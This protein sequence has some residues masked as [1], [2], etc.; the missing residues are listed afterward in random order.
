MDDT[1]IIAL[2][3]QRDERAIAETSG[4]YGDY[5][6]AIAYNI[7][8]DRQDAEECLND[9]WLGAWNAIPPDCPAN[10]KLYLAKITRNLSFNRYKLKNRKKRGGSE[11]ETL[12]D[13]I[14]EFLPD[15]TNVEK[16]IEDNEFIQAVNSFLRTLPERERGIFIR[17]YFYSEKTPVISRRYG[18]K[19]DTVLKTL[20]RTRIKL[21]YYLKGE[22]FNNG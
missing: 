18:M 14:E 10:F 17:R 7:L 3:N 22:G 4:K 21:K 20:S 8:S 15:S 9:T 5:C 12:L 6:Y 16:E 19:E 11:T 1:Q 13:E 2:Y